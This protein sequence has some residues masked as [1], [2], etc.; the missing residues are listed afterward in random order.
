[1]KTLTHEELNEVAGGYG[2]S[3]GKA[4][5][6]GFD[7]GTSGSY[8]YEQYYRESLSFDFHTYGNQ[9]GAEYGH[10]AIPHVPYYGYGH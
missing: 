10:V 1:M 3:Y 7:Y 2:P 4:Y 6:N 5:A 8:V 9:Y